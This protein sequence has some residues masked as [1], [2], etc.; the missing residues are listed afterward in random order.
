[1]TALTQTQ[2]LNISTGNG[3]GT[4]GQ[5][6]NKLLCAQL[7]NEGKVLNCKVDTIENLKENTPS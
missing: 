3:F 6:L 5:I 4:S 1:M 7:L 2:E